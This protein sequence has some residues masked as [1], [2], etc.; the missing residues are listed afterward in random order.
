MNLNEAEK[1]VKIKTSSANPS[2]GVISIITED[3]K[4]QIQQKNRVGD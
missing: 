2:P 3:I 1:K 4:L